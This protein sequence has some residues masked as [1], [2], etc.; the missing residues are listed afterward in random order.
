MKNIFNLFREKITLVKIFLFISLFLVIFVRLRLLSMPLDRDEGG[1]AYEGWLILNGEPPFKYFYDTKMPL[2]YYIYVLIMAIFGQ[3]IEGIRIGI[4][5]TVLINMFLVFK[6]V[7]KISADNDKGF[8]ASAFYGLLSLDSGTLSL[9]GYSTHFVL[10]FFMLSLIFILDAL[11]HGKMF[12]YFISG[13][14]AG[15]S[16][17][18]KQTSIYFV[19]FLLIYF[20]IINI[21]NRK[22]INEIF[23]NA[24]FYIS[25]ISLVF[26]IVLIIMKL[27][28]VFDR[29]WFMTVTYALKYGNTVHIKEIKNYIYL[30]LTLTS[31]FFISV[32][33]LFCIYFLIFIFFI[34]DLH[35]KILYIF[36]VLTAFAFSISGFYFYPHYFIVFSLPISVLLSEDF[37][38]KHRSIQISNRVSNLVYLFLIVL[39]I[40]FQFDIL[41]KLSPQQVSRRLFYINPFSESMTIANFIKNN[42]GKDSK[43]AILGSEPQ[44][45]FYSKRKSATGYVYFN[46]LMTPNELSNRMQTDAIQEIEQSNPEYLIYVNIITSWGSR[47]ISS[48][49]IMQW[50]K[51]K[52]DKKEFELIGL[53]NIISPNET[54]YI[55]DRK[56]VKDYK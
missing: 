21:I 32:F 45:L 40:F 18:V 51:D 47:S 15:S 49:R 37:S 56:I 5:I 14:F 27:Y 7:K 3:T 28:G 13:I 52:I 16:F 31:I 1:W 9:S 8:L 33:I 26:G 55:W 11:K 12:M 54:E 30:F 46:Q 2:I 24:L 35:K 4:L 20:T 42:T 39:L 41:F 38:D 50:F 53:V 29:F 22:K 10:T 44:I 23:F 6:V 48:S 36:L 34:K 43:I 17:L 25:G 19:L